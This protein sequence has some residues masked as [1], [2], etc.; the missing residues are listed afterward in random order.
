MHTNAVCELII[1][2]KRDPQLGLALVMGT[3]GVFVN[4]LND[5]AVILLP[6]NRKAV[7]EAILSL[8]TAE[9]IKGYRN[10]QAGDLE[11][12]ID[13][14][15]AVAEFADKEQN[16]LLECDINPLL[17]LPEGQGALAADALIRFGGTKTENK[18]KLKTKLIKL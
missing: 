1:G 12:I 17:V 4:F 10:Q 5:K 11:A 14:V 7:K 15:M 9:L 3:G 2:L 8:K 16:T 18:G 6:T 13:S